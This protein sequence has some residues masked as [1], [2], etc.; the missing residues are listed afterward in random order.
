[1]RNIK[2]CI[3]YHGGA[4]H[5]FQRQNNAVSIQQTLEEALARILGETVGIIGCSRTDTGVHAKEFYFNFLTGSP[6][7]LGGLKAG[8]NALLPEDIVILTCEEAAADFHARYHAKGKEYIYLVK[9]TPERDVFSQKLALHYPR[10]LDERRLDGAA[11]LFIGEHD[12]S[13]F[14]KAEAKAHLKSTVRTVYD[15]SVERSGSDVLFTVSGSGF[16]HN[17]VRIMV[18]TLLYINEGKRTE[19]DLLRSLKTGER[20]DA[21]KTIS[22]CGL[23][24]NRVFY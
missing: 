1:M 12:F 5:G 4:Y 19:A 24:L 6:I 20:A 10:E 18:G 14:C 15:F 8:M 22:P 23:Y 21:G 9:N 13:A 17:M 7:P 16:L 11:K 2:V 3:A